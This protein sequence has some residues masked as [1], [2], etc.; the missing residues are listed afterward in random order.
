MNLKVLSDH[1]IEQR[2]IDKPL[3]LISSVGGGCINDCFKVQSGFHFYFLKTN[4]ATAYPEMFLKEKRGLDLLRS[5]SGLSIPNVIDAYDLQGQSYLLMEFIGS[6]RP[7]TDFW[8]AFG[9]KLAG[10]HQNTSENFGLEDNNYIGSLEQINGWKADWAHFF[11]ECRLVPQLEMGIAGQWGSASLF[12]SAESICKVIE[13]EFP[14][15]APALLHGDLWS[16]NYMINNSGDPCLVDPAVYYGNREMEIA[17]TQLFGGFN[18]EFYEAYQATLPLE[19]DFQSRKE[20]HNL[21]P[22]LV[23]ANLFGGHYVQ[24]CLGLLKRFA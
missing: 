12:R 19:P 18:P 6:G 11:L 22:L 3:Q 7:S 2:V 1:L 17:F 15:E 4:S 14:K 24:Q 9:E 5:G 21:Y 16:G 10:Q 20:I 8:Q 23:H 13:D